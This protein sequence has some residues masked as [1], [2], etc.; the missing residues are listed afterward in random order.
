[1]KQELINKQAYSI[2]IDNFQGPMELLLF[3]I[4]KHKMDIFDICLSDLTDKYV[5]YLNEMTEENIEI[6]S[7]FIV[8]A[9]TL[10]DIKAKKLLPELSD[11]D[12]KDEDGL[13]EQ[14]IITRLIEYKKYK[15][16]SDTIKEMYAKNFG[17]F[18]K[19]F[20]KIKFD[21]KIKYT[22]QD[23]NKND[24][25]MIYTGILNRNKNKINKN[26]NLVE[27]IAVYE[28]Y[29][30]KDKVTQIVDY[31]KQNRQMVFNEM[32]S[33]KKCENMEIAT[34]FLG[35]LEL[36]KLKQVSINQDYL[37]SDINVERRNDRNINLEIS[38]IME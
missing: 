29:T 22:G 1:M 25:L 33:T 21:K 16:I 36:S 26:S 17:S 27:K 30:I 24:I 38:N 12:E 14:D 37:F 15:E 19:G 13:T 28:K 9:A 4:S 20:E 23:F 32:Y 18:S 31:L 2:K 8:M 10:L 34:A 7:E 35:V 5:E 3:L 11:E 6:A